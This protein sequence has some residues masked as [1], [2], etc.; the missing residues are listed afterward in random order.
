MQKHKERP[1][2]VESGNFS[3][4]NYDNFNPKLILTLAV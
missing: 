1:V 4:E 2:F 3:L